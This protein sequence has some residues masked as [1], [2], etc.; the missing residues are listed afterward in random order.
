[1]EEMRMSQREKDLRDRRDRLAAEV[2]ALR[3]MVNHL[4]DLPGSSLKQ[5]AAVRKA[6]RQFV[7][8]RHAYYGLKEVRPLVIQHKHLRDAYLR[9]ATELGNEG[10][11]KET[12]DPLRKQE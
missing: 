2:G 9:C 1:M 5:Q 3:E 10:R 7:K 12:A 8:E 4:L 6:L 11:L